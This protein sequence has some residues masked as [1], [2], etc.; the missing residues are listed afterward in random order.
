MT[1]SPILDPRVL[2]RAETAHRGLLDAVIG[3]AGVTHQ[4][5]IALNIST[6]S[7]TEL[8]RDRLIARLAIATKVDRVTAGRVVGELLAA[9]LLAVGSA[10]G[11]PVRPTAAG[12]ELQHRIQAAF[13]DAIARLYV[14]IPAE[15]LVATSRT[16]I[17]ITARIDA[18]L[19]DRPRVPARCPGKPRLRRASEVPPQAEVE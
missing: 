3:E 16:L 9:D 12:R 10:G 8:D 6:L 1:S 5:F 7:P 14:G 2:G 18:E 11:A 19:L 17:E 15:D 4:E 13:D